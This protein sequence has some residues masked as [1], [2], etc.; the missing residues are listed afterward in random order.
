MC[1]EFDWGFL[2]SLKSIVLAALA[3]CIWP[4]LQAKGDFQTKC[5]T[6]PC[7]HEEKPAR[8]LH[9]PKDRV[10]GE[11]RFQLEGTADDVIVSCFSGEARGDVPVPP[12]QKVIL[13]VSEEAMSDL[14]PLTSLDPAD[15][16]SLALQ[17]RPADDQ[18]QYL[19]HLTGLKSLSFGCRES[20]QEGPCNSGITDEDLTH[21]RDLQQVEFLSLHQSLVT[22]SGFVHLLA[23]KSL[24]GVGLTSTKVSEDAIEKFRKARPECNVNSDFSMRIYPKSYVYDIPR[25]VQSLKSSNA[26]KRATAAASLGI[27]G[28]EAKEAVPAL[29][30][31]LHDDDCHVRHCSASAL[32]RIGPD[33]KDAVPALVE[34]TR[35]SYYEARIT[36][37]LALG[38][39]GVGSPEA[40]AA[41][42]AIL[43]DDND[44]M[45]QHALFALSHYG[46]DAL[47]AF[48]DALKDSKAATRN[49]AVLALPQMGEQAIPL[50][51]QALKDKEPDIQA[52]ASERLGRLGQGAVPCL[53]EAFN[54]GDSRLSDLAVSALVELRPKDKSAVPA[55]IKAVERPRDSQTTR[56]IYC[57]GDLG[58]DAG[59]AVPPLQ[60]L[61]KN[62]DEC[63]H[64]A[65][66][67]ALGRIQGAK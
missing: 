11:V 47:P 45:V 63:V 15:I 9:F 42:K 29:I 48:G 4:G 13:S 59:A 39:V 17:G 33:A 64:H 12:K 26:K 20:E 52:A 6:Q 27:A 54:S 10:F 24:R 40:F 21:L 44:S 30:E 32:L 58:P 62:D 41:L 36:A 67:W 28:P 66:E 56:A 49:S 31:A 60:A 22:D 18:F 55:L 65:A 61:L 37:V 34:A 16:Y 35:D 38:T 14:S 50:L 7:S 1:S 51:C 53:M 23:L 43:S 5:D 19:Q 46:E 8:V 2:C 57:L 25:L 3:M